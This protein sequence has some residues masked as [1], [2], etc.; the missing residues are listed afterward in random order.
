MFSYPGESCADFVI[1]FATIH[2]SSDPLE[3]NCIRA[4]FALDQEKVLDD[5]LVSQGEANEDDIEEEYNQK[6]LQVVSHLTDCDSFLK[7]IVL[8]I[9]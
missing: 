3:E 6:A 1:V 5:Y 4:A 7:C 8:I 9:I 2:L